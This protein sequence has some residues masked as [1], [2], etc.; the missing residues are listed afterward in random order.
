MIDSL[1]EKTRTSASSSNSAR[2]WKS[3]KRLDT[4]VNASSKRRPSIE[5]S[6]RLPPSSARTQVL[7]GHQKIDLGKAQVRGHA[8]PR[9]APETGQ[10]LGGDL[11]GGLKALS[12]DAAIVVQSDTA[13]EVFA[14]GHG[15]SASISDE[16]SPGRSTTGAWS[17]EWSASSADGSIRLR[18]WLPLSE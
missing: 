14:R 10:A 4:A 16:K 6:M 7:A 15:K 18:A 1:V 3:R 2:F 11:N 8:R 17:L 5:N 13:F 12:L 9:L